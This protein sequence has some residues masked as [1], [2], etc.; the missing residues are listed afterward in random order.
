[1]CGVA[2]FWA[3]SGWQGAF[4]PTMRFMTD[5]IS[6]RGPDDAGCWVER[7]VGVALG[8]RRLSI[9]DL[10]PEGHQPMV[11]KSGRY[12]ISFNGEIYNFR[13]LREELSGDYSWR[14]H[15]DTEVML[16]AVEAWGL[17]AAARR[18]VGMFAFALWDR[19]ER[20]LHLVRDRLGKKPMYYGWTGG[21]FLFGS[22]LKAL[23]V[24][25]EFKAE[26]DRD[27]LALLMRYRYI[28]SPY[29]I[30]RGVYKL[31]PG[32]VLTLSS[33]LNRHSSPVPFWSAKEVAEH[34]IADP[35]TDSDADAVEHLDALLREAVR[36]RMVADVPLGAFL[37]GGVDSS[38]VV[39]LMQAQS[40][41][42]VKTFSIGFQEEKYNE[43]EHA[44]AVAR[45]IGTDHTELYVTPEEAMTVIPKLPGLYDEPFADPSQIPTFLVSEFA[46][47]QVT[48]SL[49]GDGG[50]ELFA[51]YSRYFWG[52]SVRE[53]LGWLPREVRRAATRI[54]NAVPPKVWEWGFGATKAT[55]P[56]RPKRHDPDV[57]VKKLAEILAAEN[58]ESA[59]YYGL[60]SDWKDPASFVLGSSEPPTVLTDQR[61]W[62]KVPDFLRWMMYVDL[63]SYLPDDILVKVDRA[64][65]GVS[66]EARVP[67]LDHRVVEFA[68]R[69][70]LSMKIRNGQSKWLLRQV[71]YKYVP[72]E[73]T[74][75]PKMGF[76]VPIGD[77]LRGPLREWAETLL[78][79][80][81][82]RDEGFFNPAP[83]QQKW[84]EHLSGQRHW[85]YYLWNVLMFQEWLEQQ[86]PP[87]S[88]AVSYGAYP[89]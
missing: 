87:S 67:L 86:K 3:R 48:V 71:L 73:L 76:G 53:A 7:D 14:G 61:Y 62:A 17:E 19:K 15:S 16:R 69:V 30:Y 6:H 27:A 63:V 26:I 49:S 31:G 74:E 72:K 23:R 37:S 50:D 85:Q 24:H 8:N 80:Q 60:I 75:R 43:A 35:F 44:K 58:M 79:E 55:V 9:I 42:P 70:P 2:G 57:M 47:R 82:L 88:S 46:R 1:M 36:L 38:T 40:G 83:I 4:E 33:P 52:R 51:G 45:H 11:S 28:P 68:W 18:F 54:L 29:S 39:A 12:V 84:S 32:T 41:R 10:S 34:G 20:L 81:R 56:G 65:M 66:L 21:A 5:A 78:D 25:P 59:L 64:S 13:E 22:E 89:L 77:W